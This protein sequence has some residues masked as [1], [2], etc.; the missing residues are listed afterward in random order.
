MTL[1][2]VKMSLHN[3]MTTP[4]KLILLIGQ[5]AVQVC[6]LILLIG[7]EAVQVYKMVL[8]IGRE[9]M[10]T[11]KM[12]LLYSS[13]TLPYVSPTKTIVGMAVQTCTDSLQICTDSMHVYKMAVQIVE[14]TL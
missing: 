13:D 3:L 14:E 10:Q 12:S 6:K 9:A 2:I 8:L 5:G 7:Q 4:Y 11:C 1:T